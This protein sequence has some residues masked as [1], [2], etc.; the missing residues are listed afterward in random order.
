M[1]QSY[2]L[3]K[4]YEWYTLGDALGERR[5]SE[6]S[7]KIMNGIRSEMRSESVGCL[8]SQARL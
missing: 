7:G 6:E 2:G 1:S 5:M 4:D 3:G 8:K